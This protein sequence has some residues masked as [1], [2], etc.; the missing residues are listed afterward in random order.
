MLKMEACTPPAS[1]RAQNQHRYL[2]L[3]VVLVRRIHLDADLGDVDLGVTRLAGAD[4][5][6]ATLTST[7]LFGAHLY[8]AIGVTD[9]QLEEAEP[10]EGATMPN[11]Q[12][13]EDWLK[14]TNHGEDGENAG[15]SWSV[16]QPPGGSR[17]G[18]GL[19]LRAPG[20][21]RAYCPGP[22]PKLVE[23]AF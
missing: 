4:L 18:A 11:G 23:G 10:L 9:K 2:A 21:S 6:G 8:H 20:L 12:K 15:A 7:Y 5:S 3:L 19:A 14:S 16:A 1:L 22:L 13:Y 17:R